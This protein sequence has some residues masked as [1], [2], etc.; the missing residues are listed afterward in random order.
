[1]GSRS[2]WRSPG[3][4]REVAW[5]SPQIL[6]LFGVAVVAAGLLWRAERR[7]IDPLIPSGILRGPV[8]PFACAGFFAAFFVW[9]SMI[10]LAPLRLQLLPGASATQAG[11]LLTP[12]VVVSPICAFI[13]VR[14]S[15]EP[16]TLGARVGRALCC[17]SSDWLCCCMCRLRLRNCGCCCHS[18]W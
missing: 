6:A 9:F 3:A 7:A 8:A 5:S 14:F 13:S 16:G 18:R 11:A 4:A 15:V 17:R 1:V 12:G 2:C 10:L